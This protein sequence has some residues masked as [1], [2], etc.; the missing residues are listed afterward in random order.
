MTEPREYLIR[1]NGYFYRPNRAGY[2]LEK[3]AAGLY[4]RAEADLEAAIEPENFT[5]L[6]ESEVEDA[7][8]AVNLKEQITELR[9]QLSA[10]QD[11]S[12]EWAANFGRKCGEAVELGAEVT[13]LHTVVA[14][15]QRQLSE[16]VERAEKAERE[17]DE[18]RT[19]A[20]SYRMDGEQ[21]RLERQAAEAEVARLR[22]ALDDWQ[23]TAA[24]ASG[25]ASVL[26]QSVL[27]VI[28]AVRAYL[29][30]DGIDPLAC[31]SLV[32]A[33][34]DNPTINPLIEQAERAALQGEPKP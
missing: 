24:N 25:D 8:Q 27:A 1:K 34:V 30:P 6:H 18:A 22:E 12:A 26:L 4:T 10:T 15:L 21:V 31:L 23:T 3:A 9:S 29:P 33:A 28:S 7:P 32:L 2:T 14:D 5:V 13:R 19:D 17:R 11:R 20:D 16:A